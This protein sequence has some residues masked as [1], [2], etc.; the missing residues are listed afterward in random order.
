MTGEKD[1]GALE[2]GVSVALHG[3]LTFETAD[4]WH[5][6]AL[7]VLDS[8]P[9]KVTVDLDEVTF[10]DSS[11]MYVLVRLRRHAEELGVEMEVVNVP[12]NVLLALR[13]ADLTDY[14]G[15]SCPN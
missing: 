11:G 5:E 2:V 3:D 15:V 12:S 1:T 10:L 7:S 8:H 4:R 9:S 6:V 13:T 14:L